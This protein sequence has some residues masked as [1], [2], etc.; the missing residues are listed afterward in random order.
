MNLCRKGFRCHLVLPLL[1]YSTPKTL[2]ASFFTSS[3]SMAPYVTHRENGVITVSPKVESEQS[4]L[5]VICHGLGD[6]A[7]G[8]VDVAEV[9]YLDTKMFLILPFNSNIWVVIYSIMYRILLQY[10][11]TN[12]DM[13]IFRKSIW[14]LK[15]H[16]SN[17]FS[18]LHLHNQ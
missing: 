14:L 15:C 4:G 7:E 1:F 18:Q 9:C 11:L 12:N 10:L 3:S 16:T 5:V 13:H 2:V 6:T 8:F 17:L